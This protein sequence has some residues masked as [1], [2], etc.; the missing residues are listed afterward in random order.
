LSCTIEIIGVGNELLVG[1][2]ANTNAQWLSRVITS[3]GAS[4]RRITD[5][6]DNIED[7]A[8]AVKEALYRKPRWII[9]TGGLGPT[10]DDVTLEGIAKALETTLELSSTAME[11]VK[12][13]YER[14]E[15]ITGEKIDLTPSRV[16][17]AMLP[18][19]SNP[20]KNPEGTAPGIIIQKNDTTIVALPGVP[21]EMQAIFESSV[22]HLIKRT[23]GDLIVYEKS[24]K[25]IGVIESTLAPLIERVMR[26]YPRV[27]IKSHPKA[28]EPIPII[29]LNFS[30][31]SK[32]LDTAKSDVENAC[33]ELA[34][35]I[36]S[37]GGRVEEI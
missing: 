6:G 9:L 37:Q 24:L 5:V 3:L 17:M 34:G 12:E 10:F 26:N 33:R 29:E 23:A 18:K 13:R 19:G 36:S 35:L 30:T 7:I 4:V 28:P 31:S 27:Y 1:K 25:A 15:K 8:S 20:L 32:S 22:Q 11:M 21:K 14:Y 2:I 16:K